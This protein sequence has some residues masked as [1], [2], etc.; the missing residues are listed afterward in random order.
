MRPLGGSFLE[1]RSDR[2]R[3]TVCGSDT[4]LD[5]HV[6]FRLAGDKRRTHD[7]LVADGIPTPDVTMVDALRLDE[8]VRHVRGLDAGAVIKPAQG[9]GGGAGITVRPQGLTQIARSAGTASA[10]GRHIV[11]QP[12][13][14]GDVIRVLGLDGDVLDAV[15]R[16]PATVVGNGVDR[17]DRLVAIENDRRRSLGARSTGPIPRSTDYR[18]ALG[19]AGMGATTIPAA[20]TEVLVSGLSNTG[21]ERQ[22]HRLTVSSE[23]AELAASAANAIG[24]RLAGVDVVVDADGRPV[25]VLEVN[26]GPGLHWHV[27]VSEDPFDPFSAIL[28]LV[29]ERQ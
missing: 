15:L 4:S 14:P 18:V 1:L 26:T 19:H 29:D 24:I 7:L 12:W 13:V 3:L 28:R 10:F 6:A 21:S 11:V 22:S 2:T 27:L 9:S 25:T 23:V 17:V 8:V 5:S 20:G 16:R